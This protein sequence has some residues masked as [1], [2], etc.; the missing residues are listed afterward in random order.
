MIRFDKI[1]LRLYTDKDNKKLIKTNKP[2]KPLNTMSSS[3]ASSS[4]KELSLKVMRLS[5]PHLN[6]V[7]LLQNNQ[8]LNLHLPKQFGQVLL[9]DKLNCYISINNEEIT[10]T[11][12]NIQF[13]AEIQSQTRRISIINT[14]L[15]S[16]L[17]NQSTE[18]I[19]NHEIIELG[20]HILVCTVNY[21]NIIKKQFRKFYKFHVTLPFQTIHAFYDDFKFLTV[22]INN[23]YGDLLINSLDF[24]LN[25]KFT[26]I[27]TFDDIQ[28]RKGDVR[29]YLLKLQSN[30]NEHSTTSFGKLIVNWSNNSLVENTNKIIHD[31]LIPLNSKSYLPF[32]IEIKSL[33]TEIFIETPFKITFIIKPIKNISNPSIQLTCNKLKMSSILM[34]GFGEVNAE[35]IKDINNL[36]ETLSLDYY[37]CTIELFPLISGMCTLSGIC[38]KW[39]NQIYEDFDFGELFVKSKQ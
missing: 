9:S 20:V 27:N 29:E 38:V 10:E 36:R 22:K 37:Q 39:N 19:F 11:I 31:L 3:T 33:P 23:L 15:I 32:K 34:Y 13:R 26:I 7:N 28:L 14:S 12:K 5:N 1:M 2:K 21:E 30:S 35:L 8:N 18:Y 4:T 16:L 17:P 25:G 24:D 6:Q